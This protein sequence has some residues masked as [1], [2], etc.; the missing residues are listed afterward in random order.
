MPPFRVIVV[1]E[2]R[3]ARIAVMTTLAGPP[4]IGST[5][6]LPD[7][8]SVIVRH[9]VSDPADEVGVVIAAPILPA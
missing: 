1:E 6:E 7:G 4:E 9:V 3:P 8:E 2:D 5:I